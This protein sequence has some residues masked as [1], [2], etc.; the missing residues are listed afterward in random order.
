MRERG[1]LEEAST[2]KDII[3][4][5]AGQEIFHCTPDQEIHIVLNL[6]KD[7]DLSQLPVMADG[8]WV[9]G[10]TEN[11]LLEGVMSPEKNSKVQDIMGPPFPVVEMTTPLTQLR[12]YINKETPAVITKDKKGDWQIITNYDIIQAL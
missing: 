4:Q 8:K 3:D 12:R 2:V 9:G 7:H 6:M 10:I 5:K 11:R 1:F